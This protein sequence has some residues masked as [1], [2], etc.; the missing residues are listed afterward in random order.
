MSS[1]FIPASLKREETCVPSWLTVYEHISVTSPS[2]S[3]MQDW[4]SLRPSFTRSIQ[5]A[6]VFILSSTESET[7]LHGK[8]VEVQCS[9]HTS[10]TCQNQCYLQAFFIQRQITNS[11]IFFLERVAY[12]DLWCYQSFMKTASMLFP[13]VPFKCSKISVGGLTVVNSACEMKVRWLGM[14]LTNMLDQQLK[15]WRRKVFTQRTL[16]HGST[17]RSVCTTDNLC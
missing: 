9:V 1:I 6:P 10:Y 15:R 7:G 3:S 14:N 5:R 16:I 11:F 17:E 12:L 8:T 4:V 2:S 13:E